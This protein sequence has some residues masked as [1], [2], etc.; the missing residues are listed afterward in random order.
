MGIKTA[1]KS[2]NMQLIQLGDFLQEVL[3]VRP[4][5]GMQHWLPPAQLEVE[6]A[7]KTRGRSERRMLLT[8]LPVNYK[9]HS[10][11]KHTLCCDQL[12]ASFYH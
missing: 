4:Q 3:A 9:F 1:A 11:V 8:K 12:L 7:L 6:D 2:E 10:T 5:A